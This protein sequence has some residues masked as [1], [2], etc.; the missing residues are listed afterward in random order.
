MKSIK[1]KKVIALISI[2]VLFTIIYFVTI[3]KV[4][5]AF[6]DSS[7]SKE[8]YNSLIDTIKECAEKYAAN[9]DGLFKDNQIVYIKVQDL[10]DSSLLAP[11]NDTNVVN[12]IDKK[13]VLNS[14]VIKI[15][16][17]DNKYIIEVDN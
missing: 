14:N 3:S 11:N 13:T 1:D 17:E 7:N 15:K 12:P 5:Y 16:K 4:S 8:P 6:E 9:N 10:I 2:L